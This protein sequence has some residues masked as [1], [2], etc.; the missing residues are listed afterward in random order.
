MEIKRGHIIIRAENDYCG[1]TN[2]TVQII[3]AN[4]NRL[5]SE[6]QAMIITREIRGKTCQFIMFE[7]IKPINADNIQEKC[8]CQY[9]PSDDWDGKNGSFGTSLNCPIHNQQSHLN[10][11]GQNNHQTQQE[12]DQEILDELPLIPRIIKKTGPYD[13]QSTVREL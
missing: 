8:D 11:D 12:K 5:I 4:S 1:A 10:L 3:D 2:P 6:I 13:D 7:E 9:P